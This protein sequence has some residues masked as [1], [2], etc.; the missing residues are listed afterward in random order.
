M[1]RPIR[2]TVRDDGAGIPQEMG[3]EINRR[4]SER[5]VLDEQKSFGLFYIRER[6][7]LCYGEGYGVH[8]ESTLGEGTRVTITL[9]LDQKPKKFDEE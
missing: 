6:I 1:E 8:V 7:Q 4:M 9:P 2:L 3:D 5:S